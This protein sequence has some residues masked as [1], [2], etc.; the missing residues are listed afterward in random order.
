MLACVEL[1]AAGGGV[2]E[3]E[4]GGGCVCVRREK[5]ASGD[6]RGKG[7][8]VGSGSGVAAPRAERQISEEELREEVLLPKLALVA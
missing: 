8:L 6:A 2:G 3:G 4:R 5:R 7:R 1:A